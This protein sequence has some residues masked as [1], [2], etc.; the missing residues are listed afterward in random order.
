MQAIGYT[1]EQVCTNY[2][3]IHLTESQSKATVWEVGPLIG[4]FSISSAFKSHVYKETNHTH[5]K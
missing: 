4:L 5:K 1:L 3:S 2:D